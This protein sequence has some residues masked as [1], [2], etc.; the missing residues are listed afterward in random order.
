MRLSMRGRMYVT[1][2][3]MSALAKRVW[4]PWKVTDLEIGIGNGSWNRLKLG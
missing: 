2:V 4:W 3:R 1:D